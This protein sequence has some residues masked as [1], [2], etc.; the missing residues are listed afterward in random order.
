MTPE[1]LK[2]HRE[3]LDMTQEQFASFLGYNSGRYVRALENGERTITPRTENLVNL[4]VK[5]RR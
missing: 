5:D 3:A 1:E 2:S 4:L